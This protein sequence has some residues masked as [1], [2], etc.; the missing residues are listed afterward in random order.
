M[1]LQRYFTRGQVRDNAFGVARDHLANERTFLSWVRTSLAFVGLGILVAELV[2]TEGVA[3]EILGLL[4]IVLGA[5]AAVASTSRYLRVTHQL[6]ENRY[7][8]S[9]VGPVLIGAL[10]VAVAVVGL[11]FT[12][13]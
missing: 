7:Q 6:D 12:L 11:V 8:S 1:N 13:T 2:E 5:A 3:A 9:T 4:L 10:T